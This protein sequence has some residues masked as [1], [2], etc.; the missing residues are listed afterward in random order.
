MIN[1]GHNFAYI[2]YS[3]LACHILTSS[4][5]KTIVPKLNNMFAIVYCKIQ[6]LSYKGWFYDKFLA[7][8]FVLL[9]AVM[10]SQY[11]Q[12]RN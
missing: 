11:M 6:V 5:F 7:A 2:A 3:F 1:Y 10:Y 12:I 8:I 4:A 9:S